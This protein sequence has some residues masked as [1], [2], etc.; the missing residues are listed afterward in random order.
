[1]GFAHPTPHELAELN[2]RN[3]FFGDAMCFRELDDGRAKR[4]LA[5]FA[6]GRWRAHVGSGVG[7]LQRAEHRHAIAD[8]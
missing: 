6:E 5:A 8:A 3:D 2:G 7:R 1:M 4:L